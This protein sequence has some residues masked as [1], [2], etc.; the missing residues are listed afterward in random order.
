MAAAFPCRWA[1]FNHRCDP[2]STQAATFLAVVEELSF[3]RAA[4][5]LHLSQQALSTSI[6]ALE[7]EVK[8]APSPDRPERC[9]ASK[10]IGE[11]SFSQSCGHH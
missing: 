1:W 6:Q 8:R 3:T 2:R 7:R 5:R 9:A 4:A 10:G 11:T